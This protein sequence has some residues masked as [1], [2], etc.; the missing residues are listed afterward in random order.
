MCELDDLHRGMLDP[1]WHIDGERPRFVDAHFS[2]TSFEVAEVRMR[3]VLDQVLGAKADLVSALLGA[4]RSIPPLGGQPRGLF[5][6]RRGERH[7]GRRRGTARGC[8]LARSQGLE[9]PVKPRLTPHRPLLCA[10]PGTRAPR[11]L[12]VR[13]VW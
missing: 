2:A 8:R 11:G 4:D 10:L 7:R 13:T 1:Q 3:V 5:Q 12:I 9:Q 6:Q